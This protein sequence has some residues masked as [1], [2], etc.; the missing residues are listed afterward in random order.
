MWRIEDFEVNQTSKEINAVQKEIGTKKKVRSDTFC[1][2]TC[3]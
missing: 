3:R 2:Y 1:L